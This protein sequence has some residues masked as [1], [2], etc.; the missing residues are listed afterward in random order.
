M[1]KIPKVKKL[2]SGRW[3]ARAYDYTD[4]N[5]VRH[6]KS[7]TADT[8]NEALL[9]AL[10]HEPQKGGADVSYT[11]LT[12][13]AAYKRYIDTRS[14]TLAPSTIAE[15]RR[16]CKRDFPALMKMRL[17]EITPE[18]VQTA[19]NEAVQAGAS[20]KSVRNMHGLLHKVLKC[21]APGIILNTDLPQKE[22]TPVYVPTSDEVARALNAADEWLRVP[23]LLASNGSLRR[24]EICALTPDDV[25][26]LGVIINKAMVKDENKKFV[27]KPPKTDAGY[28]TCRLS[29]SVIA[30]V[31]AW[32]HFGITPDKLEHKWQHLKA[33]ENLPFKFHAFRH[34]WASLLHEKG[35]P[36]QYIAAEGGWSSVD[37]LHKIYEHTLRDKKPKYSNLI[38]D[39]FTNEFTVIDGGKK[40]EKQA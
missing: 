24:S 22:R 33:T 8:K 37:M 34:Y 2:P 27:I 39:I 18:I 7:F 15:Y 1:S 25:T 30:E 5:K 11:E 3:R 20:P 17:K 9:A 23:I 13:S 12:L 29:P 14:K 19:V 28:R 36:D 31:R 38:V 4:E 35:V 40:N 16:Q 10:A 32:A 26:D 6:Y 21:Y